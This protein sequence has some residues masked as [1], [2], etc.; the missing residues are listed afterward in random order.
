M[1]FSQ[2]LS[3]LNLFNVKINF[4][5]PDNPKKWDSNYNC[6]FK[7]ITSLKGAPEEVEGYFDCS[8]NFLNDL[9]YAPK[10]VG[11]YFDC[12]SNKITSFKD[13]H[14]TISIVEGN[15]YCLD[16]PIQTH[17]LGLMLITG[18]KEI[19]FTD[20]WDLIL[21]RHLRKGRAGLIDC[22]NEL[23]EE[24]YEEFAQI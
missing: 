17:V 15:F 5:V 22:Q 24:G 1:K 7:K 11:G 20:T 4:N 3:E 21:N 18:I 23:I 2:Y 6:T 19:I 9:K 10:K 12:S 14:K 16:N 8:N 13:I